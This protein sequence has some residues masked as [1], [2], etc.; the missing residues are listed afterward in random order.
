MRPGVL[1]VAQRH[2]AQGKAIKEA[3][4]TGNGTLVTGTFRR[5]E[6]RTVDNDRGVVVNSRIVR[7]PALIGNTLPSA[8]AIG[9]LNT[10]VGA[11]ARV[12]A[13]SNPNHVIGGGRQDRDPRTR[14]LRQ[15]G[16]RV[17]TGMG[18]RA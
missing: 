3:A 10:V 15:G 16:T 17:R 12:G 4:T 2:A 14:P 8:G 11:G 9:R 13:W 18:S 6:T 1:V 7:C 5:C